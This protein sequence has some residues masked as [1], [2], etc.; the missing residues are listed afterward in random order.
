MCVCVCVVCGVCG[1]TYNY[2]PIG[3]DANTYFPLEDVPSGSCFHRYAEFYANGSA[4]E[5]KQQ[6]T[7]ALNN[8]PLWTYYGFYATSYDCK[9]PT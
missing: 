6:W 3:D 8:D 5:I 2:M 7:S 9:Y 4:Q 1:F